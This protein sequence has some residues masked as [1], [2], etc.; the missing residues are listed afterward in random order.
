[1][2]KTLEQ[3]GSYKLKGSTILR[4]LGR[5]VCCGFVWAVFFVSYRCVFVVVLLVSFLAVLFLFL[6][7][8]CTGVLCLVFFGRPVDSCTVT[9]SR[10]S[11]QYVPRFGV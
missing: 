8:L 2:Q 4:S 3:K 11:L 1:M 7:V 6:P 10:T 9:L 5:Y